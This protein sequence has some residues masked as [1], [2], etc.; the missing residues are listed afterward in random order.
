[1]EGQ[2]N[3]FIANSKQKLIE[4]DNIK[5]SVTEKEQVT[6]IRTKLKFIKSDKTDAYI[7]FVSQNPKTGRYCGVRQ[8]SPYPK[9]VCVLDKK[10]M[11]EILTNV[12]YDVVLIPMSEKNGYV[13]IEATPCE[14]KATVETT[15][16]PKIAYKVEVKFGNKNIVFDPF[17][18]KKESVRNLA[19]CRSVLEK[20]V[21]IKNITQVVEDFEH[22][23]NQ[24]LNKMFSDGQARKLYNR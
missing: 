17:D 5:D 7:S 3:Y 18:G 20:R 15:Y 11:C 14:F 23:A 9:K 19:S 12:L 2:R 16:V 4:M 8:D 24:I 1:M 6:K 10:L 22:A 21:D 13:V